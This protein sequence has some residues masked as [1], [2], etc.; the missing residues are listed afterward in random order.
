MFLPMLRACI[1]KGPENSS[2]FGPR[3]ALCNAPDLIGYHIV[4]QLRCI[5]ASPGTPPS[6]TLIGMLY[7][8]WISEGWTER[9]RPD[10]TQSKTRFQD[11]RLTS[12]NAKHNLEIPTF[13]GVCRAAWEHRSC[14]SISRTRHVWAY[15]PAPIG[16]S[17]LNDQEKWS[18]P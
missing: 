11:L 10:P 12:Q 1:T 15:W 17:N 4:E 6:G 2:F 3:I 8:R 14:R 9:P 7:Y 5:H 16:R 18:A 13:V